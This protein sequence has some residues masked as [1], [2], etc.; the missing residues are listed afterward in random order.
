MVLLAG[1]GWGQIFVRRNLILYNNKWYT[2]SIPYLFMKVLVKY[3]VL[4]AVL[5]LCLSVEFS[6]QGKCGGTLGHPV[7]QERSKL[8]RSC[9]SV[10]TKVHMGPVWA[11]ITLKH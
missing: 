11:P 2:N 10:E 6:F 4:V 9:F 3:S 7:Q 8:A 1:K 5:R